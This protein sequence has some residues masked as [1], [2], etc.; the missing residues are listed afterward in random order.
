MQEPRGVR[1]GTR[2]APRDA[3]PFPSLRL[4][5]AGADH[6]DPGDP[7]RLETGMV[8]NMPSEKM[9]ITGRKMSTQNLGTSGKRRGAGQAGPSPGLQSNLPRVNDPAAR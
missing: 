8:A 4:G 2:G 9:S 1:R 6:R 7:L 3:G 5:S